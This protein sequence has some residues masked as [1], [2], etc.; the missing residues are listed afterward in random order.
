MVGYG[1]AMIKGAW[2]GNKQYSMGNIPNVTKQ[3]ER[4]AQEGEERGGEQERSPYTL[5]E[6][7]TR[8]KESFKLSCHAQ[9][10][11]LWRKA[12]NTIADVAPG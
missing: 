8:L 11:T 10:P 6:R 4:E 9:F 2:K 5:P 7:K 1:R 12:H 3:E